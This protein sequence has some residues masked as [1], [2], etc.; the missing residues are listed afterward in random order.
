MIGLVFC[1]ESPFFLTSVR[2]RVPYT[3]HTGMHT[4]THANTNN[5]STVVEKPRDESGVTALRITRTLDEE[6]DRDSAFRSKQV[7]LR[8]RVVSNQKI[9]R[10]LHQPHN[11][12]DST[13]IA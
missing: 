4:S 3:Q 7:Q 5:P 2:L 13:A 9:N 12:S 1:L 6:T 8:V 11:S 10:L